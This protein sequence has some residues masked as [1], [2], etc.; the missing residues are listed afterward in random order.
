MI[1]VENHG[2]LILAS[3]YWG[4]EMELA[5]KYYASVNAGAIRVMVPRSLRAEIQECRA[6]EYAILSRG[7]WP[8]CG[9]PEA[10]EILWEDRTDSPFA[11]QWSPETFD[12]LPAE[13]QPGEQWV[14]SLWDLKKNRP[15]KALERPCHWRR[16]PEIPWLKPL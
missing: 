16:V 9:L 4:S 6:A 12:L 5:G 8:A 13:P 3:N 10:V 2:P 14:I 15:H 7:P 11:W 1:V